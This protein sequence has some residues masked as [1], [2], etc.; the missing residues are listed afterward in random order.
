MKRKL[1][2]SASATASDDGPQAKKP[3]VAKSKQ[4]ATQTASRNDADSAETK[5]ARKG[6]NQGR[7]SRASNPVDDG[8]SKAEI[9]SAGEQTHVELLRSGFAAAGDAAKAAAMKV[10]LHP[11]TRV[12]TSIPQQKYMRGQFNFFGLQVFAC[13]HCWRVTLCVCCS[14]PHATPCKRRCLPP[15]D[16]SPRRL[17]S[18][19]RLAFVLAVVCTHGA[20]Q[21]KQLWALEQR[22]FQLAALDLCQQHKKL[23]SAKLF[24]VLEEFGVLCLPSSSLV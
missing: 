15:R 18:L 16:A 5:G 4:K 19:D 10:R 21:L 17:S 23:W 14:G 1:S 6:T 9:A 8:E 22:E 12:L 2:T 13:L 20:L 3:R 11:S 24:P 7:S